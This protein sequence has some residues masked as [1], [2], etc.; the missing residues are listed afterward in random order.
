MAIS[1]CES[2]GVHTSTSWTSS[3]AMSERQS[4]S[5]LPQPRRRAASPAASALRPDRATIDGASGRSKN[6]PAVRHACECAAPMKA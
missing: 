2:P 4:V 5:T 6:R 1:A 3:R